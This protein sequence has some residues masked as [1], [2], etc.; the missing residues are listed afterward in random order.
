M[1]CDEYRAA[2][3][4]GDRG[5]EVEGHRTGCLACA[6]SEGELRRVDGLL[7]SAATWAEPPP[8]LEDRV[9]AAI[10]EVRHVGHVVTVPEPGNGSGIAAGPDGVADPAAPPGSQTEPVVDP[11]VLLRPAMARPRP[12]RRWLAWVAAAAVA[13]V[14]AVSML[15]STEPD[16]QVALAGEGPAPQATATVLGWAT[17]AGTR[18]RIDAVD[19]PV[20]P[21]GFVYELWLSNGDTHLSAGS[22][23]AASGIDLWIGVS[24]RDFPRVWVTMEPVDADATVNGETVL[25]DVTF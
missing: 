9:Q 21:D 20:A 12:N 18:M 25:D 14:V 10:A 4:G 5:P 11:P 24:R 16:W 15:R 8:D 23:R 17:D 19:L 13:A 7:A 1:R 3:L 2:R 6:A 22:F